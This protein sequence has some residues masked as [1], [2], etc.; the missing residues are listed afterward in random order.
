MYDIRLP[1]NLYKIRHN[2]DLLG[3]A[4]GY[5]NVLDTDMTNRLLLLLCTYFYVYTKSFYLVKRTIVYVAISVSTT[6]A[7]SLIIW[8]RGW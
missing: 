6:Q 2:L 1:R 4:E 7:V 5:A 3:L 8:W